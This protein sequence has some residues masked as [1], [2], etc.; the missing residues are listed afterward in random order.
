MKN[1]R[2][3]NEDLV[4]FH[5]IGS[6]Y[7]ANEKFVALGAPFSPQ[8]I[9]TRSIRVVTG[10][11]DAVGHEDDL[12]DRKSAHLQMAAPGLGVDDDQIRQAG[13]PTLQVVNQLRHPVV[14]VQVHASRPHSPDHPH[15]REQ[16]FDGRPQ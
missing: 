10:H 8:A 16:W 11:V 3:G 9:A 1:L 14:G 4:R 6:A 2:S 12:L 5:G 7:D 13:E 15:V